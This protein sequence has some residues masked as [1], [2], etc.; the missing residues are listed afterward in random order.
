MS[1]QELASPR[2][3]TFLPTLIVSVFFGAAA[4][5]VGTLVILAYVAPNLAWQGAS[6][7][8]RSELSPRRDE[9]DSALGRTLE[10]A[11]RAT[12]ML[13]V[14]K[15]GTGILER[16]YVPG[17]AVAAGLVLT[18][19]GWL[20]TYGD[21]ALAKVKRA[22]DLVAVVGA[23]AYPV[24]RAVR[25]PYS[26][27]TFLKVDAVNLPVTAFGST[28][29]IEAGGMLYAPDAAVGMRRLS[30][31]AFDAAPA[32]SVDD[33]LRSSERLQR[34]IRVAGGPL[35]VGAMVLS[36]KGEVVGVIAEEGAFGLVVVPVEA[37]SGVIGPVLRDKE[38]VRPVLGL[39]YVDLSQMVSSDAAGPARGALVAASADGKRAAVLKKGPAE[40][41]GIKAGDL[42]VAVDGEQVTAKNPLADA[43]AEYAA[44]DV[45]TL[46]MQNGR[47]KKETAVDVTL[48]AS[49][50]P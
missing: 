32:G 5:A 3:R 45:V 48:G 1:D 37:F 13:A 28:E 35:P 6:F 46:T 4:G 14:A 39:N 15:T 10:P 25:D 41:A 44:G 33:L 18:S 24:R 23:K 29:G 34:V 26:G 20:V 30:V 16:A 47:T 49:A 22:Q 11:G 12:V 40:A 43:I 38:P 50:S 7:Q 17:D 2:T 31:L 27:I 9:S 8:V 21:A 19:D 42:V 36:G